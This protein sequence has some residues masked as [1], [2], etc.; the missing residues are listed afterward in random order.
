[1]LS[2]VPELFQVGPRR[3]SAMG[4]SVGV[5]YETGSA[6]IDPALQSV[7][8]QMPALRLISEAEL[9]QDEPHSKA[10]LIF[11]QESDITS[12]L[13]RIAALRQRLPRLRILV[14]FQMMNAADL[15]LLME[16]GADAFVAQSASPEELSTALTALAR[17]E[18]LL[19]N[20]V[21]PAPVAAEE[22]DL[23]LTRRETE[24]LRLLSSGFSNKEVA[25][26]L[27][28]GLRTVE[29]HRFNLR[30]KTQTGRL[31]DLVS[32]ARKLRL[33]P[34]LD[35]VP[36]QDPRFAQRVTQVVSADCSARA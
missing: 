20:A 13:V 28:I 30:R 17:G 25:R 14:A 24:I 1:M 11:V 9:D 19:D 16:A 33:A 6:S 15:H 35:V 31:K 4:V 2:G 32:L 27:D 36:S 34:V 23:G 21:A 10:A 8:K 7:L 3:A 26:R 12:A 29:T 18:G 5:L 22:L